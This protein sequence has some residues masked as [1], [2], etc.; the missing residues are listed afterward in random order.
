[1][2]AANEFRHIRPQRQFN[3]DLFVRSF[4]E[5]IKLR[6]PLANLARPD[7]DNGIVPSVPGRRPIKN[8]HC[9]RPFLQGV[10]SSLQGFTNRKLEKARSAPAAS[11]GRAGQQNR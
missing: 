6:Q 10:S 5:R 8:L 7:P 4:R 2:I 1:V 3:P 9:E 11:E